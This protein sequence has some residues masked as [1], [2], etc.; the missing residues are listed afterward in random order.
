MNKILKTITAFRILSGIGL[1]FLFIFFMVGNYKEIEP[2]IIQDRIEDVLPFEFE[3]GNGKIVINKAD[4]IT[5][6]EDKLGFSLETYYTEEGSIVSGFKKMFGFENNTSNENIMLFSFSFD[7]KRDDGIIYFKN[8]DNVQVTWKNSNEK[9]KVFNNKRFLK[10]FVSI[11]EDVKLYRIG[12]RDLIKNHILLTFLDIDSLKTEKKDNGF[13]IL[14]HYGLKPIY[15][16]ILFILLLL[17]F[18]REIGLFIFYIYNKLFFH[19]RNYI[20]AKS[21]RT[22]KSCSQTIYNKLY[23]MG[24]IQTIYDYFREINP[25]CIESYKELKR[26]KKGKKINPDIKVTNFITSIKSIFKK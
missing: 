6:K 10:T 9:V 16:F 25:D 4:L 20:C 1:L 24:T 26:I 13:I 12:K 18:S 7:I 22:G 15:D 19:R 11:M 2:R 8:I 14:V 3:K 17:T 21:V 23:N 5:I